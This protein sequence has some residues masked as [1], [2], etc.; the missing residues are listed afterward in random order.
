[1][2]RSMAESG[3]PFALL[4]WLLAGPTACL[5]N[6][7]GSIPP[8]GA[9]TSDA[10]VGRTP[11]ALSARDSVRHVLDGSPEYGLYR[12]Q[13]ALREPLRLVVRDSATWDFL[14]ARIIGPDRVPPPAVDFSRHLVLVA[15]MG[16]QPSSGYTIR[17]DS[18]TAHEG[19]VVAWVCIKRPGPSTPVLWS[20]TSPLDVVI[21]PKSGREVRFAERS[22]VPRCGSS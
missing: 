14:W 15:A 20:V 9:S 5:A 6:G 18:V 8:D 3:L 16:A 4:G 19:A 1:M 10:S 2:T 21:A 7:G 17:I 12:T 11:T 22:D 13:S